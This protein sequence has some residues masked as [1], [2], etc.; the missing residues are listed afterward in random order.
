MAAVVFAPAQKIAAHLE[1]TVKEWYGLLASKEELE[2]KIA[3]IT[4]E[5]DQ[6]R[7]ENQQLQEEKAEGVRLRALLNMKEFSPYGEMIGAHIIAR[8]PDNW[9]QMVT[10]DRGENQGVQENM[11]VISPEGLVGIV[12]SV[13]GET[14]RVY[15]LTDR[16]VAVGVILQESRET[17]GIVEGIGE[18]GELRLKNVPYYSAIRQGNRVITSGLSEFYP[19][20]IPVGTVVETEKEDNGLVLAASITPAVDFNRLEEVLVILHSHSYPAAE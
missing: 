1:D 12:A 10:I 20:G 2:E 5:R 17:N 19:K 9:N 16:S 11:A 6:L 13:T 3:R 14:A 7:L 15:L 8:S 4:E 18:S